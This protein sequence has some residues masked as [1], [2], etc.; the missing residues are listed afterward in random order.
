MKVYDASQ[1]TVA[2]AGVPLSG[3]ASG[4]FCRISE[5]ADA[6]TD[7]VGADGEVVRSKTN[8]RRATVT[9]IL[10]RTSDSNDFLSALANLD[11][12]S[13]NG[14]GVGALLIRDRNG[15]ALYTASK[16]WIRKAPDVEFGTEAGNVEWTIRCANLVRFDGGNGTPVAGLPI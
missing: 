6:F 16:A 8:D 9:V 11:K 15:R 13:P 2:F 4:A 1:V 7:D 14:A 3:Y 5:E 12:N 10:Q